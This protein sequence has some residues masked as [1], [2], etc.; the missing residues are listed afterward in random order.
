M[1]DVGAGRG[2]ARIDIL[3]CNAV[4]AE[5]AESISQML[6]SLTGVCTFREIMCSNQ[7][8]VFLFLF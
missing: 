4:Q 2:G 6:C 8:I 7:Q 1:L 3:A 5:D